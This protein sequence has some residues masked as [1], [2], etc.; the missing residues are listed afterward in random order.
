[1]R[2][3]KRIPAK[4]TLSNRNHRYCFS[5]RLDD[6][7]SAQQFPKRRK[8][9]MFPFVKTFIFPTLLRLAKSIPGGDFTCRTPAAISRQQKN[10][11]KHLLW[12]ISM[13]L[14]PWLE[15]YF[16]FS[17][18]FSQTRRGNG[19]S[20][21]RGYPF[22]HVFNNRQNDFWNFFLLS[23]PA[24]FSSYIGFYPEM[25]A[26]ESVRKGHVLIWVIQYFN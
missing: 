12:S 16:L 23:F 22:F 2:C 21:G 24:I 25:I 9:L 15:D 26:V 14:S 1:M 11:Q 8:F 20:K 19:E 7:F 13:C 4:K 5:Q 18:F 10:F 6:L 3:T 17:F